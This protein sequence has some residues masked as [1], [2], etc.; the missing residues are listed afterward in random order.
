MQHISLLAG[1]ALAMSSAGAENVQV[2]VRLAAPDALEVSYQLPANCSRLPFLKSE[3]GAAE[4]RSKW[5]AVD[6]CGKAN[7]QTLARNAKSCKALTFRV[8]ATFNKVTGYPG[9]FPT[10][11]GI[12]AHM[13]N[14]AVGEA[15]GAVSYRFAGP[16]TILSGLARHE[17]TAP[18]HAD[19]PALLFPARLPKA[20][21]SLDYYD[22][23]LPAA[24]VSQLR[25][26]AERTASWL[27][28][29]MPGAQFKRPIIAATMAT[30]P[31]G[32]NIGGNAGDVLH[33]ALFNWPAEPS[34]EVSRLANKLVT[35]EMSHRFQIR[36]A[37][38]I[39]TDA[40]LIHE[41]G[42]EFLRWLVSLHH[43]WLTPQDAAAELDDALAA[44]VLV[45]DDRRWRDMPPAEIGGAYLEYECGL[46]AYAYA[47]AARQG[48][49][50]AVARI[51]DFYRQLRKGAKPD[52]AQAMECGSLPCNARVLP[53]VL[54]GSR[55]MREEWAAV[56][57]ETGLAHPVAPNQR[58]TD[59]MMLQA[60][61]KL[62][63]EDC[64]G[65]RSMTPT[66]TSVLVE[67][68]PSC[69][70]LRKD[71]E[72][73]QVEGLPLFG[74]TQAL[75]AM[76]QACTARKEVVLG[77]KDGSALAVPCRTPHVASARMYAA[78]IGKIMRAL[79]VPGESAR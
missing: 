8:P 23:A 37:A 71:V 58:Q 75:P 11:E 12:Y 50:D 30:T 29:R 1:L 42:G 36:D 74:G 13:S 62:V 25:E 28:N 73:V 35:H 26:R 33:L 41:G 10:G 53:A 54:E 68:L 38:D 67:A 40:R 24:T 55:A 46:P 6:D 70:T 3:Q 22:P 57:D 9:S 20:G 47:M 16:G 77:L 39:Y 32:P 79:G 61:T 21:T 4:I 49:R 51:D 76:S 60:L 7:G 19:A 45:T 43:G 34:P 59:A 64:Q 15:C 17:D 56:L 27:H 72:V 14:Y 63:K 44:C 52:F 65:K 31:G 66:A 2:T 5:Q 48:K 78:D 69:A 18:A